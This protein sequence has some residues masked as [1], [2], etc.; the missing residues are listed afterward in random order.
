M[1]LVCRNWYD[2]KVPLAIGE[3]E[4]PTL[5]FDKEWCLDVLFGSSTLSK[6]AFVYDKFDEVDS[7]DE[8]TK[9]GFDNHN[10]WKRLEQREETCKTVENVKE[11]FKLMEK[12][13]L[14]N[15]IPQINSYCLFKSEGKL[16]KV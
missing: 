5:A 2:E 8:Y 6:L 15:I 4:L 1:Q 11:H 10:F 13:E 14:T 16:L 3:S 7:D 9:Q 12:S